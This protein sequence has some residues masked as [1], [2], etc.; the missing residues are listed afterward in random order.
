MNTLSAG[1]EDETAFILK[2]R[3]QNNNSNDTAPH[4]R[5]EA[6]IMTVDF[7]IP[8]KPINILA[9]LAQVSIFAKLSDS[10]LQ[11]LAHCAE[12]LQLNTGDALY[13]KGD[14]SLYFYVVLHGRLRV[15][16]LDVMLGYV[17]RHQPIGEMDVIVGEVR[18]TSV[19]AVR[20]SLLLRFG[21]SEF[22]E[23][24]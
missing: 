11:S 17:G 13:L 18:N 3:R 9:A 23:Y 21:A 6:S 8:H 20:D 2:D 10:A 4:Y 5:M 22:C 12:P 24:Q 7:K 1:E 16:L 19:H 14:P 15:S